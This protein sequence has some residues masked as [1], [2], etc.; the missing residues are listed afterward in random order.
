MTTLVLGATGNVGRHVVTQLHRAGESVRALT[1]NPATARL[2][3]ELTAT[4]V[5]VVS[6]DLAAPHTLT[7]ALEGATGMHLITGAGTDPHTMSTIPQVLEMARRAGVRRVSVLGCLATTPVEGL[8]RASGLEW[9]LLHPVEFM[10]NTLMWARSIRTDGTVREPCSDTRI[11]WVHEA[12][13][14]A[15]AVA[16]ILGDG[17][18]GQTYTLTGPAA[19]T[20]PEAVGV[21]GRVTGRAI[22][23]I[24]LT[25]AQARRRWREYGYGARDIELCLA[26]RSHP[27]SA[28]ST[29]LPTVEQITGRP[30]RTYEHWVAEHAEAFIG[31]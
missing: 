30:A 9:T 10:V 3:R 25:I 5:Q 28:A 27:P 18:A 29:V 17:H 7:A 6:G 1:R 11:A 24:E 14:A 13:V 2:P 20:T 31:P 23:C 16:A 12:D 26:L 21:I 19:L 22:T 8:V 4:G 15:V